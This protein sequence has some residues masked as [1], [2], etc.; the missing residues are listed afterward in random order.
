MKIEIYARENPPCP[1]CINAKKWFKAKN[2]DFV[3]YDVT[4]G[5]TK[6][7][8]DS[9]LG[10]QARTVPQIFINDQYIGGYTDLI[11]SEFAKSLINNDLNGLSL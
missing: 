10:H 2:L 6:I 7:M 4:V 1:F 9:R 11:A 8:L 5:D 3:E